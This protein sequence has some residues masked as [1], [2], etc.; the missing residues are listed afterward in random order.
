MATT[1]LQV[2]NR[3]LRKLGEEELAEATTSLAERYERLIGTF[4][5]DVK[6]EVEDAYNWRALRQ[7]VTVAFSVGDQ[8]A[9]IT[10]ANERSRLL[11]IFQAQAQGYVPMCF[12]ITD[13]TSVQQLQE[14]DLAELIYRDTIDTT[15]NNTPAYF[16]LDN[17]SG[18]VLDLFLY[19]R[20]NVATTVQISLVI[21]QDRLTDAQAQTTI[22]VPV[23]PVY[24]G[25][26]YH[27]L[28]ERGEELGAQGAF[29]E[30]AYR[31]ALD[32]AIGRDSAESGD[33][34]ELVIA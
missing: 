30:R 18:D 15:G 8:S 28:E 20:P 7:T 14:I 12:D 34:F 24:I 10:E 5:N 21:P 13:A 16:A 25:A 33:P 23:R 29:S 11:R 2:I 32:D 1:Y 26:V 9:T 4:V 31:Q 17:S 6:E 19:P 27:A 22:K 3:V